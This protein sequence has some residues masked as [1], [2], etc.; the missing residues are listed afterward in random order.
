MTVQLNAYIMLDGKAAEAIA[1]Y[2]KSLNAKV[3]FKETVGEGAGS[4][5]LPVPEEQKNLV[6][7]AVLKVADSELFVADQIP[8]QPVHQ[9]NLLTICITT[10]DIE[11]SRQFYEALR[12]DG[13]VEQPLGEQYFSPAF[14]VVT[15]R[16][17]VTF[18]IFTKLSQG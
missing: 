7:H 8:G 1:F 9:G 6:A 11:Q 16:F 18:Q 5:E 3:L 12:Q 2:E 15:D 14:A 10:T 4:P 17:G 13:R